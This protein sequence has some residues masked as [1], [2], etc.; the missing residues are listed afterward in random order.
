MVLVA[1]NPDFDENHN[2]VIGILDMNRELHPIKSY[3]TYDELDAEYEAWDK[4]LKE[5]GNLKPIPV[6]YVSDE[7]T[8]EGT[9]KCVVLLSIIRKYICEKNSSDE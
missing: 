5:K 7:I 9:K 6:Q 8:H 2:Y 4:T 1:I 3:A